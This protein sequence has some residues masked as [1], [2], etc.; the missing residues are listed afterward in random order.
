MS[1][2]PKLKT[3]IKH[4]DLPDLEQPSKAVK[5]ACPSCHTS[6]S[7][8][9]ININDLVAKC[10]SCNT[11]FSIKD[12]VADLHKASDLL[13]T[14][15]IGRPEGIEL[16]YFHDEFEISAPQSTPI[17]HLL[18][19]CCAPLIALISLGVY[20]EKGAMLA[21]YL[22]IASVIAFVYS[23]IQLF[24]S[25][26][27]RLYV[28]IDNHEVK[29]EHRPKNFLSDQSFLTDEIEQVYVKADPILGG[30]GLFLTLNG[31][32][33]QSQKRML[34]GIKSLLK[35]KYMEQEIEKYL[36]IANKKVS[37]ELT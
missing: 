29:V 32:A 35:A 2:Q 18:L 5:V 24:K 11:V 15:D 34:G 26:N 6:V 19:A 16:N 4:A 13:Y 10:T 25:R 17:V 30:H 27:H 9:E 12:T 28:T 33:G 22:A 20:A 37:G 7:A 21:M 31:P 23:S 1:Y 8:A 3:K 36:G 14:D